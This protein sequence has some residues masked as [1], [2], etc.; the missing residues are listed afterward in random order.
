VLLDVAI[1]LEPRRQHLGVFHVGQ[2]PVA[3]DHLG[4]NCETASREQPQALVVEARPVQ[5]LTQLRIH[6][7]GAPMHLDHG[8]VLVADQVLECPVL[9]ALEPR[10]LAERIAK[11][12]VI[13]RCHGA[14]HVPR[15]RELDLHARNP[16]EHLECRAQVVAPDV[17][18]G[19]QQFVNAELHPQLGDLVHHDE[20]H[21]VVLLRQR[22]LRTEQLREL[23]IVAVTLRLAE[24]PVDVL[25]FERHVRSE[26]RLAR[27]VVTVR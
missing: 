24:I 13:R 26:R 17:L 15:L 9:E 6:L 10:R 27:V 8:G 5:C 1:H 18:D 16:R 11:S 12:G 2:A 25:A 19:R 3:V 20:K 4:R 7:R 21:L 14:Q 22:R 23:Q